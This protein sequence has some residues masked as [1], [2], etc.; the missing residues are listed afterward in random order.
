[1]K[2]KIP[3]YK[4]YSDDADKSSILKVLDRKSYWAIGPEIEQF[5]KNFAKFIGTKYCV[6]FNSGTSALHAALLSL[7]IKKNS[8]IIVPSFTFI[9]SANAILMSNSKP[10]FVDIEKESL[11]IDPNLIKKAISKNT[12]A[13]IPVHYAGLPCKIN[14]I[15]EIINKK[16]FLIEDS[17]E[18]L[19][20]SVNGKKIGTFGDLSI[21]SFAGNK[22]L[23]TGEGGSVTTNSSTLFERLKL[24]RSHGRI[25]KINYFNTTDNSKYIQLGYNWRMS[26][27]TAAIG[28]SQL[29]KLPKL[30]KM[31]RANAKHLSSN[32]KKLKQIR[33]PNEFKGMKH[34]FQFYSIQLPNENIRNNLKSFLE[35]KGI[36]SKIYFQPIHKTKFYKK[37]LLSNK[38][39]LPI[40]D[41]TSK[42]IL[43]LPMYPGLTKEELNYI[44]DSIKEFFE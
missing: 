44:S 31:R 14:E 22:I 4:V 20:S 18:A 12:K 26:S 33:L 8:E 9:A 38:L 7:K 39:N 16:L 13:I 43:T 2:W 37:T 34:V 40:T 5:E 3:L 36:M 11:G 27:I 6:T 21:F 41:M 10:K 30:I 24:I 1:M 42:Q 19:G 28:L 23:T 15:K 17:A 25:E 32:L 29:Q 35:S